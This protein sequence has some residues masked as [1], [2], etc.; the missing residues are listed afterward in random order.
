MKSVAVLALAAAL[1]GP[2][3]AGDQPVIILPVPIDDE[4]VYYTT[5][6][7]RDLTALQI[8]PGARSAIPADQLSA[9]NVAPSDL[10]EALYA[11]LLAEAK[12]RGLR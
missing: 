8:Q 5:G 4:G 1:A 2:A 9:R 10:G 6:T 12:S 7:V 3:V 11:A